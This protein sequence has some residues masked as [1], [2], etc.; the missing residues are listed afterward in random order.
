MKKNFDDW[1][2]ICRRGQIGGREKVSHEIIKYFLYEAK[3]IQ[4]AH[5]RKTNKEVRF[6]KKKK[7]LSTG[8]IVLSDKC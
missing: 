3:N 7:S 5:I 8:Y 4:I 6:L 1:Y 2:T